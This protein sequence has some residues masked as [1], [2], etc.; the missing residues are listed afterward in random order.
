MTRRSK[1]WLALAVLFDVVNV[2]GAVMA[3]AAGELLHA[4]GHVA[5]LAL[6]IYV[7]WRLL[8]APVVAPL[9]REL[10]ERLRN[11]EQAVDAVAIEVE[12]VGEGQRFMTRVITNDRPPETADETIQRGKDDS[13][14]SRSGKPSNR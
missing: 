7:T 2:A 9:D 11:I 6:G 13:S 5:L 10:T 8:P 12:R 3:A 4:G 1:I 14:P